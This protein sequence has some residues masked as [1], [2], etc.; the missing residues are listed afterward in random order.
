VTT[1][2]HAA[3]LA[4]Q[5]CTAPAERSDRMRDIVVAAAPGGAIRVLDLGCGTGSLVRRLA[6]ALPDASIV[7]IDISPA[8]IEAARRANAGAGGRVRYEV[9]DYLRFEADPFDVVVSDGVLHLVDA[10][11]SALVEKLAKDV[12]PGGVFVCDMPY[13]CAYNTAF[14]VVRRLLRS[15]R[16]SWT[17]ELIFQIARALHGRQMDAGSLRERVAYMY[18]APKRVMNDRLM[19]AFASAGL[20]RTAE[21]AARS[22][23]PSQLRHRVTVFVR[24]EAAR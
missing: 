2:S 16:A 13:A 19:V 6:D 18:L 4:R 9:A 23:S 1:S 11:T 12:R 24:D 10:D 20:R 17:D 15:I 7:G 8:N 5:T 14:A 21:Y 22:T 3:D